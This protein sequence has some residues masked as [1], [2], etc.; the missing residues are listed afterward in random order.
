MKSTRGAG[1]TFSFV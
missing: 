1:N